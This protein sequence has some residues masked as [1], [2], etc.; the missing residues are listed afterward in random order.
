MNPARMALLA[1]LCWLVEARCKDASTTLL[2][3]QRFFFEH[4]AVLVEAVFYFVLIAILLVEGNVNACLSAAS[5]LV[6]LLLF[7]RRQVIQFRF[8]RVCM[9]SSLDP[10]A[11]GTEGNWFRP[12]Y[13]RYGSRPVSIPR[14][15]LPACSPLLYP[16]LFGRRQVIQVRFHRVCMPRLMSKMQRVLNRAENVLALR[17]VRFFPSVS[18]GMIQRCLLPCIGSKAVQENH[19][20]RLF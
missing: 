20:S 16:L 19:P 13:R 12:H 11:K 5:P 17:L 10:N 6:A 2:H 14:R 3:T 4:V 8:Y 9:P 1:R 15:C 18:G 7:G